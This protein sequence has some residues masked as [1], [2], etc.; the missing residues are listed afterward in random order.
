MTKGGQQQQ[1]QGNSQQWGRGPVA[2]QGGG[3][4][5]GAARQPQWRG[6]AAEGRGSISGG[7]GG[8]AA[9]EGRLSTREKVSSCCSMAADTWRGNLTLAP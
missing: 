4:H 1:R 9:A 5:C 3:R 7:S 8:R 2:G 6:A